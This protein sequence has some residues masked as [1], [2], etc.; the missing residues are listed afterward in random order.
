MIKFFRH[1]RQRLVKEN[2]LSKYLLYAIGEIILVVIGILIALQLNNWK[3]TNAERTLEKEYIVSL[4]ED[5]KK[6]THNF[7]TVIDLNE[8]RIKNLDSFASLCFAYKEEN[9]YQVFYM[10]MASLRHPDFVSQT[11][12]TLAQ[13][14]NAGGMRLI[15]RKTTADS[16]IQYEDYFKKLTNQQ[17]WCE[18]LLKDLVDAGIPIFNFKYLPKYN[19][20]KMTQS[21]DEYKKTTKIES[22]NKK[23]IIGLGNIASTY[24]SI[25]TYYVVLLKS[26]KQKS[27]DLI[28]IL[29]RDYEIESESK[30]PENTNQ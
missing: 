1:I 19:N 8:Q 14:K 3:E 17:G 10:Y 15:T 16:I 24:G 28:K 23:L 21:I 30:S 5:I 2:K 6:D 27:L 7:N 9:D 20:G 26:G 4:I 22:P 18:S 13:L 11:D 12:R 29:E 25:T